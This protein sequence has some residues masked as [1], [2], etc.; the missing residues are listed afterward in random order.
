MSFLVLERGWLRL[1]KAFDLNKVF[2]VLILATGFLLRVHESLV[3]NF[4]FLKDQG[5]DM[6]AVKSI[7]VE[8]HLTLIGPYTSLQA[9][10]QGPLYYYLLAIPFLIFGGDPKGGVYLM[11]L[12][13]LASI[14]LGYWLA[15]KL[16]SRRVGLMTALVFAVSPGAAAAATFIWNPHPMI[17]LMTVYVYFFL[18]MFT[19]EDRKYGWWTGLFLGL[20]CHFQIALALPLTV[21]TLLTLVLAKPKIVL[22][23]KFYLLLSAVLLML[24]PLIFFDFRHEHLT[25][26]SIISLLQGETQGLS[27]GSE[28][29]GK[30]LKG[31]LISFWNL[32]LSSYTDLGRLR[33]VVA[34][35]TIF[36]GL[37]FFLKRR[38]LSFKRLVLLPLV[39]FLV[40]S[41]YPFQIWGWYLL[42]L[43][44]I[45]IFIL[46]YILGR[47][48]EIKGLKW[49]PIL[50]GVSLILA[51]VSKLKT[52][53]FNPPD[54]GGTSK[55]RGKLDA[56]D[57]I[58]KD[59]EDQEFNVLVFTPVVLTDAYDYLFWW[60]GQDQYGYLPGKEK[61]GLFYLLMEPD[62]SKPW[63]Y[64][65]WLETVIETGEV[66]K[67]VYLP[68]GF[69]I[70]KRYAQT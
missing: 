16:F 2:L 69:I 52:L 37:F 6:M 34:Y 19:E 30:I 25:S 64:K 41:L 20:M 46:G 24:S 45:F 61:Q 70:Q 23:K 43:Y 4:L 15:S 35:F 63:S 3:G 54:Y 36:S 27:G 17:L 22:N 14:F 1:G 32:F 60:H 57:Y 5:R 18:K 48:L 58:Y 50:V 10:F 12:L 51:S 39:L 59:A 65:G 44:P 11:L 28:P 29:Y 62:S 47:L 53:Y 7:V 56:I 40:Y 8:R 55:I 66:L 9:T 26:R 13:S 49:I 33:K 31:H 68:S 21:A 67:E 38:D 42:G